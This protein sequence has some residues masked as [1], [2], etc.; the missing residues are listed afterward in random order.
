MLDVVKNFKMDADACW[1]AC[2]VF[3]LTAVILAIPNLG[4]S[5][6]FA[7]GGDPIS[8]VI[9]NVIDKLT[10]P[11]G[12]AIA[13]VAVVFV[14]IGLFLGKMSWGLAIA[15]GIGIGAIFGAA[16]IVEIVGGSNE[17]C[18]AGGTT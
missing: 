5:L 14:G 13:T 15:V 17:D 16:Q 11:V 12:R 10:G 2:I 1:N 9:C 6:A 3:C 4:S 7:T 18:D 8:D